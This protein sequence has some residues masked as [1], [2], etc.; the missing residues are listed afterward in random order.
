[1]RLNHLFVMAVVAASEEQVAWCR[2]LGLDL[3]FFTDIGMHPFITMLA[4]QRS[5]AVQVTGWGVPQTS[6]LAT[7][8]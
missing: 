3:L 1:M 6:G 5:A 4:A 8:D 2:Q 7:I